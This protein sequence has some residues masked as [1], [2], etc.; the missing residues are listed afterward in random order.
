MRNESYLK[1]LIKLGKKSEQKLDKNKIRNKNLDGDCII[2]AYSMIY[3]GPYSVNERMIMRKKIAT[4]LLNQFN[5]ES[6][7][8][9]QNIKSEKIHHKYYKKVIQQDLGLKK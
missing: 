6:S 9:W 3:L 8:Y 7:D 4:I 2:L 5:I 1:S